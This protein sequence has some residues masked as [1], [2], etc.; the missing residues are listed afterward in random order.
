[1]ARKRRFFADNKR[2]ILDFE[3]IEVEDGWHLSVV[4]DPAPEDKPEDKE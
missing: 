2:R 1:M 4:S 3:L